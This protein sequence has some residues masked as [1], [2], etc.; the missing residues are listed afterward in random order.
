MRDRR[1]LDWHFACFDALVPA[2]PPHPIVLMV[3]SL[4]IGGTERQ[5]VELVRRLD[6]NRFRVHLAC[7]HQRG[8]LL[9]EVPSTIRMESFPLHGFRSTDG[10][11]Q[12]G[13]FARWCRSIGAR[14]VHTC[15]LYANIFGLTGAALAGV[16][17]R[18]GSR[19][20][21]LTG[22]KSRLQRAGQHAAYRL[23]HAVVAN[24]SAAV[25]QL[26]R[27]GVPSRKIRLIPNGVDADRFALRAPDG[28]LRR[29]AMVANLRA[30]K[31]HDVLIDAA[32]AI[33]AAHPDAEFLL[34][35][36]GPQA[37][38]LATRARQ[39]GVAD[40]IVFLGACG[41]VP[42]VLAGSDLFV[43]PSRSE[44]LPNAVIEA[45]AAGLPVVASEVGGIPELIANG[46]TGLM[47]R[48][49]D[50]GALATAIVHLLDHPEQAAALGQAARDHVTREFGFGRLVARVEHLYLSTIERQAGLA[51]PRAVGA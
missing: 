6:P 25:A 23:A 32:P 30:E 5:T 11:V 1:R 33:L 20:E 50:A 8:A 24:S 16:P 29:I 14:L 4:D 3:T 12:L 17:A 47:V 27:E 45:M 13:R 28:P 21:V 26:E 15:D 18:I 31:G 9:T 10:L 44:A 38:A 19:R 22:D 43:L 40:R 51:M 36:D 41:N 39:R 46:V 49:G 7:F 42:D 48:P 34:A 2:A 37:D 35:G